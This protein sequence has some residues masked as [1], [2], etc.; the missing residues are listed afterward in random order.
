[1]PAAGKK[2]KSKKIDCPRL[3]LLFHKLLT[4]FIL[5][6]VL[7]SPARERKKIQIVSHKTGDRTHPVDGVVKTSACFAL[8][9]RLEALSQPFASAMRLMEAYLLSATLESAFRA[10]LFQDSIEIHSKF[11]V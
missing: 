10:F 9:Y 7:T 6:Q 1:L 11:I 5:E 8:F 4:P 3:F 2:E